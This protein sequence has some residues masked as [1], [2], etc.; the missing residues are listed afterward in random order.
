MTDNLREKANARYA[1]AR[2]KVGDAFEKGRTTAD[3]AVATSKAKA[4]KAAAVTKANAQK[5]A[6]T[7]VESVEKNP[8]VAGR[9]EEA[10]P[11]QGHERPGHRCPRWA[12]AKDAGARCVTRR[13]GRLGE[14]QPR[15]TR[16]R[17]PRRPRPGFRRH[18][19]VSPRDPRLRS[20]LS[21]P[22]LSGYD[23]PLW[24]R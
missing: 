17:V 3:T 20:G 18:R 24:P 21:R 6:K 12:S 19:G 10:G 5:A 9:R 7:T 8:I 14:D 15:H 16:R 13:R 23:R 2:E 1:E 22:A 11:G 4:A